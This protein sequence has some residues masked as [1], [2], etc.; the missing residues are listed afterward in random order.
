MFKNTSASDLV[1]KHFG[2]GASK[3]LSSQ[4]LSTPNAFLPLVREVIEAHDL[5]SFKKI[6]HSQGSWNQGIRAYVFSELDAHQFRE[7]MFWIFSDDQE[8]FKEAPKAAFSVSSSSLFDTN[9][10]CLL[11]TSFFDDPM[12]LEFIEQRSFR[13]K[14]IRS[15]LAMSREGSDYRSSVKALKMLSRAFETPKEVEDWLKEQSLLN[16]DFGKHGNLLVQELLVKN[17]S[18]SLISRYRSVSFA[19]LLKHQK[20]L[21]S[22]SEERKG[23]FLKEEVNVL[24]HLLRKGRFSD[25]FEWF[26]L[27][28]AYHQENP[29]NSMFQHSPR[30]MASM[31]L[32]EIQ[33][34]DPKSFADPR[35]LKWVE[36]MSVL[37][38]QTSSS[39][40]LLSGVFLSH[41]FEAVKKDILDKDVLKQWYKAAPWDSRL[42]FINRLPTSDYEIVHQKG[43]EWLKMDILKNTHLSGKEIDLWRDRLAC[44]LTVEENLEQ[45]TDSVLKSPRKM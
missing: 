4:M 32:F 37:C 44:Q 30:S 40:E 23:L 17:Q 12:M 45:K 5:D 38:P 2:V 8:H 6:F 41:I 7:A 9:V 28:I 16:R 27:L 39:D 22:Q 20:D 18:P 25:A 24:S 26:D 15:V 21:V 10:R 13:L 36:K 31:M 1:E 19:V 35:L 43:L 14:F 29:K 34:A 3:T 33:S 42:R 11:Q